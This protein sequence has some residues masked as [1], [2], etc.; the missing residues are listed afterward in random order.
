M[1]GALVT[2]PVSVAGQAFYV[3]NTNG[4][5]SNSGKEWDHA[6]STLNYAISKCSDDAG[7]VI[8]IA[9]WHTEAI[10]DTGTASGATTDEV[11]IDKCGIQIIGLGNGSLRPTFTL[12]GATDAAFVVTAATTNIVLDNVILISGIADC[13]AGLT[14]TGTS[15]GATIQNC[16]FRSGLGGSLEL[17]NAITIAADC[18]N[19]SI[20]DSNFF[21]EAGNAATA[22]ICAG[23]SDNLRI[24]RCWMQGTYSTAAL[25]AS[26]A[27]S[28]DMLL[29]H[30]VFCNQGQYT[31]NLKT[32]CT[33][34]IAYCRVAGTT[35]IADALVGTDAMYC[36]EN[37]VT[38]EDGGSGLIDPGVAS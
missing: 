5:N 25:K 17:V 27:K 1:S 28:T 19:V 30:S 6:F 26:A 8:Y 18:D 14:L 32:D 4:S 37:Y 7:D 31:V 2:Q 11:V 9:P 12:S 38:G 16:E 35:S 21:T 3:D 10:E 22:V 34:V 24:E 20:I 36:C 13:A 15:D 29:L 23:G 33:G